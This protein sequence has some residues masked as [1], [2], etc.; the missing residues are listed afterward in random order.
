[1][2]EIFYQSS[3]PRSGSTLL[4]NIIGQNPDFYV[5]PTSGVLDLVYGARHNFTTSIEFQAQDSQLMEDGFRGFC[6]EGVKGFFNEITDKPYVLDKSRG[7]IGHLDFL[8]FYYENPRVICMVRDLR[9]IYS[10]MEKIYRKNQHLDSGMENATEMGGTTTEKRVDMWSQSQPVGLAL[11]RLQQ[12]ILEGNEDVLFIKYE[13]L[14]TNPNVAIK[15]LY[16]YLDVDDFTHD[17]SAIQQTTKEDDSIYGRFG[18]HAIRPVV[19]K[20]D[21]DYHQILGDGL[22]N[23][24]RKQYQW[25]YKYFNYK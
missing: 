8:R 10:S 4:Q 24:I 11:D 20:N 19:S 25:F 9:S 22:S 12:M 3:L 21:D 1:M 7:W 5:T 6:R 23:H 14:A 16:E 13:H 18:D 15:R 2:K 17:F